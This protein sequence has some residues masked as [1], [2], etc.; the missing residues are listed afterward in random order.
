LFEAPKQ[1]NQIS[2]AS[3]DGLSDSGSKK[4]SKEEPKVETQKLD[5]AFNIH[6]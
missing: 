6:L 4:N 2:E 3:G 1:F 5:G